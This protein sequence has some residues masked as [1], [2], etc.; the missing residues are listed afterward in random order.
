MEKRKQKE[1]EEKIK[2]ERIKLKRWSNDLV[3][4][5]QDVPPF[6]ILVTCS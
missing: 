2:R 4:L 5:F 6:E 1:G 3:G